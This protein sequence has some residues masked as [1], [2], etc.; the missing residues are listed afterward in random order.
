MIRRLPSLA[1]AIVALGA[2]L[3]VLW[4]GTDGGAAW[5]SESARRLAVVSHPRPL[6]AAALLDAHGRSLSLTDFDRPVVLIDFIYTHCPGACIA[7][8]AAFRRL[9]RDFADLGLQD[10]VQLLS[11]TFD[12]GR[13]GPEELARYLARFSADETYWSAARF[14]DDRDLEAVL[15]Q[16]GVV[17]IPEPTVGFVHNTAVYLAHRGRVVGIY[18]VDDRG[19]LLEAVEQRLSDGAGRGRGRL[20][21]KASVEEGEQRDQLGVKRL[22]EEGERRLSDGVGQRRDQLGVKRLVERGERRDQLG[23]KASLEAVEWRLS[24]G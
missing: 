9:Q 6:P 14:K 13:D 17:V 19:A 16:L 11:L 7:M 4:I 20:G 5:T 23:V 24:H 15:E 22:I 10:D 21:A 8:G 18:D 12:P 1:A 3:S 2:G